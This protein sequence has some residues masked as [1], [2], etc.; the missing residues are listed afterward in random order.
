MIKAVVEVCPVAG[1]EFDKRAFK[2]LSFPS[3][4]SVGDTL[5]LDGGDYDG[6]CVEVTSISFREYRGV[7]LVFIYAD[8]SPHIV[9]SFQHETLPE[10]GWTFGEAIGECEGVLYDRST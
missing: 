8:D 10:M 6:G 7:M 2:V 1:S 9:G 5:W 4:P 3:L